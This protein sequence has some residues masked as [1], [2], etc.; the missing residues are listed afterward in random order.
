M[1]EIDHLWRWFALGIYVKQQFFVC[2]TNFLYITILSFSLQNWLYL[3]P[4]NEIKRV[5]GFP[6]LI[7]IHQTRH[8]IIWD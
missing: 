2:V 5:Y 1:I 7:L 8:Q 3:Y 4:G 6:V